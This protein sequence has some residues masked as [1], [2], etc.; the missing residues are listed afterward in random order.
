[1]AFIHQLVDIL[2]EQ[3]VRGYASPSMATAL[4]N[5]MLRYHVYMDKLKFSET[6]GNEGAE[7]KRPVLCGS[8]AVY[9]K[10]DMLGGLNDE[11]I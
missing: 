9:C 2:R 8:Q 11:E 5:M 6:K 4:E 10:Y 7:M 1:M 3:G